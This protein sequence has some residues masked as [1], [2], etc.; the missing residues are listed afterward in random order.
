MVYMCSS[1][2]LHVFFTIYLRWYESWPPLSSDICDR[3]V[4]K[5]VSLILFNFI[6]LMLGF[7]NDEECKEYNPIGE[8]GR[9]AVSS[10]CQ[11]ILTAFTP[12]RTQTPKGL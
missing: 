5:L 2:G 9:L 6:T 12:G 11:D 1:L 8:K 7:S 4:K 3:N 10:I